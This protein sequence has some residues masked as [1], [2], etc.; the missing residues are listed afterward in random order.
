MANMTA[1]QLKA[2]QD[3][4]PVFLEVRAVREWGAGCDGMGWDRMR[5]GMGTGSVAMGYGVGT[6]SVASNWEVASSPHGEFCL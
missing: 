3:S 5:Y 4:L 2:A 6:G 1:K